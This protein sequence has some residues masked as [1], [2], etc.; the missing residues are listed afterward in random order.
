MT[1]FLNKIINIAKSAQSD[2]I[3]SQAAKEKRDRLLPSFTTYQGIDPK[4]GTDK[5]MINGETNSG[6]NL[7]S[8]ASLS[9]GER[10]FLRQNQ[11]GGLQRVD[12]RNV[13]VAPEPIAT[14]TALLSPIKLLLAKDG[15][16]YIGGDREPE[17][18]FTGY[19]GA[20]DARIKS[21]GAGLGDY[22][23]NFAQN[24]GGGI[25][26]FYSIKDGV[27]T[28]KSVDLTWDFTAN[29]LDQ[30]DA[31]ISESFSGYPV[32]YFENDFA[33]VISFATY[34]LENYD[35]VLHDGDF[36]GYKNSTFFGRTQYVD[37]VGDTTGV[38][39]SSVSVALLN[40]GEDIN[41]VTGLQIPL[42]ASKIVDGRLVVFTFGS[43]PSALSLG[44]GTNDRIFTSTADRSSILMHSYETS[45]SRLY[46]G[47][48][49][50][51]LHSY[52]FADLPPFT[53]YLNLLSES[54]FTQLKELFPDESKAN[55]YQGTLGSSIVYG[56]PV[57]VD[58]IPPDDTFTLLDASVFL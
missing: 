28:S 9:I 43:L 12:A 42:S 15:D 18:I 37:I 56:S 11:S 16:L 41:S 19:T 36:I 1:D 50:P 46:S 52:P 3:I 44:G 48:G 29:V 20:L 57:S 26:D 24:S 8:N 22:V 53:Q 5:V 25:Y 34:L 33:L 32:F 55:I 14:V 47:S 21:T 40:N 10:V 58:Y 2:R 45:E 54:S 13:A 4:D 7:I 51:L 31:T 35:G 49:L 6:F 39:T 27:T 30:D 38:I 23:I 17:L